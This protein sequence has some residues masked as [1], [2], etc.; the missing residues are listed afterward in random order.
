MTNQ[1]S[2]ISNAHPA[3]VENLY[4]DYKKSPESIDPSWANF[5]KGFEYASGDGHTENGNTDN[6]KSTLSSVSQISESQLKKEIAVMMLI[7]AYRHRGHLKSDTN[8][9]KKRKERYP[10]LDLSEFDL[11]NELNNTFSAGSAVGLKNATLQQIVD[12]LD[13]IYCAHIGF[14]YS[15]IEHHAERLWLRERIETMPLTPGFGFSI[16]K[17]KRIL[18][19]LNEAT[20]LEEFLGKKFVGKKRFSLEG[21]ETTI[22]ALDSIINAGA[23][24]E[25]D[26]V[27]IGMAHRGRLNVLTN[28]LGKTYENVFN[29]FDENVPVIS[30]GSGDVKYHLGFSS[31]VPTP[32]G[33]TVYLKLLPNPS[34]LEAVDAVMLG[35]ARAKANLLYESNFSRILPIMIHGDAAVAGQ[36]IVY[37]TLQMSELKGYKTGGTIH[38]VINN[39]IGFT[40]DFEDARTSNYCTSIANT[41]QAPSFH[42]NGDDPEAV[43]FVSELAVAYRNK[44]KSDVFIDMVCYRK[45]GHNESD[46]PEFTQPQMWQLIK[47]HKNPRELYTEQLI[48]RSEVTRDLAEKLS[49]EYND[50]LQARLNDVKQNVLPYKYQE[51][52]IAWRNLKRGEELTD[53]DFHTSPDTGITRSEIQKIID[54][55]MRV[56]DGFNPLKDVLR[57]LQGKQKLLSDNKIDWGYGELMAYASL[58]SENHAVRLS[59]EDV[60]RGTFSHR[61]VSWFDADTNKEYNRLSELGSGLTDVGL[62]DNGK[63][64]HSSVNPTSVSLKSISPESVNPKSFSVYNSLLSEY[65]V[66]GFEFGYAMASPDGLVIWEAQFGDFSNG[67]QTI[68]DQF[69]AAGESK[70]QRQNG[71]VLLL[72]HGYEGQGPEHSSARMERMLQL[73]AENNMVVANVTTPANLFHIMRRQILRPFRKPLVIMSPKSL[74]RHPEVLSDISEFETGKSFQEVIDDAQITNVK[75]VKKVVFC[76]GKIYYD[77][78]EQQKKTEAKNVAVVRIEQLYPFPEKQ[79]EAIIKKYKAKNVFWAQEEPQNMGAFSMIQTFH[80]DLGL[81][82]IGRKATA[83]P[84]TGYNKVHVKEQ[85]E[86]VAEVLS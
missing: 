19:K 34:H 14:E 41:V 35:F 75:E 50:F 60:K 86:I 56:P 76:T 45:H 72:P 29:E 59:G 10:H 57:Y 21:G 17:K 43:V 11:E 33:K 78:L 65:A 71:L 25:V 39:Q 44:F 53:D 46:N 83:S 1:F 66:M 64:S 40:T 67:A 12:K 52:E 61:H 69:I 63:A 36:G 80:T 54:H 32:S 13:K 79:V 9:L 38:F 85:A 8:P 81:K 16:D 70:W 23:A 26:E 37:E 68:I 24:D 18:E 5:F 73:C 27:I 28:I 49:Q 42:V 22:P 31:Q 30:Y 15:H 55:L 20:G 77:I 7:D 62:T 47:N 82:Y 2:Y 6:G 4:N 84:A 58:V 51:P 3:F 74:L 48:A